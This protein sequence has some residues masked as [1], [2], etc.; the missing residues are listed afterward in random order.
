MSVAALSGKEMSGLSLLAFT[1]GFV[2]ELVLAQMPD[3]V[4]RDPRARRGFKKVVELLDD[5]ARA[6]KASGASWKEVLPVAK[7]ANTL[8]MSTNGGV[9]GWERALRLAQLTYTRVGNP[10]YTE[11]EFSVDGVTAKI[12]V[13]RLPKVEQDLVKEAAKLFLEEWSGGE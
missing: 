5:R 11:V 10:D 9:E 2:A 6:L 12:D 4:P 13:D 8:R 7:L 1:K 3:I